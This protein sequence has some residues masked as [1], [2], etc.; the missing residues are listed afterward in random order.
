MTA[1]KSRDALYAGNFETLGQAMI[2]NNEAQGNLHAELISPQAHR[3]IEIAREHGAIGWKV[4]GAGGDG[5]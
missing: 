3:I 2:E 1:E 5:R 4:N